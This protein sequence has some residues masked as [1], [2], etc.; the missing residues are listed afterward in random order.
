MIRTIVQTLTGWSMTCPFWGSELFTFLGVYFCKDPIPPKNTMVVGFIGWRLILWPILESN[1]GVFWL[2]LLKNIDIMLR[3]ANGWV[4][5]KWRHVPKWGPK[6]YFQGVWI[7]LLVSLGR[8]WI[9][10]IHDPIVPSVRFTGPDGSPEFPFKA[11]WDLSRYFHVL[12]WYAVVQVRHGVNRQNGD[13]S[14]KL[15]LSWQF[16]WCP[17]WD[18][19]NVTLSKVV[20]ELQLGDQKVRNWITWLILILIFRTQNSSISCWILDIH[21]IDFGSPKD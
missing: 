7:S 1:I 12:G 6:T 18:G 10:H 14:E 17:F 21:G 13:K 2:R 3:N 16:C 5:G 9:F 11:T 8:F 19:E 20:G 4:H 15:T